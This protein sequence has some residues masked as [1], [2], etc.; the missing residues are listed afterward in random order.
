MNSQIRAAEKDV[1]AAR[2]Q[3]QKARDAYEQAKSYPKQT[4]VQG[5]AINVPSRANQKA[6]IFTNAFDPKKRKIIILVIASFL[7]FLAFVNYD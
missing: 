3:T 2:T 4:E 1:D 7:I 6:N 5:P